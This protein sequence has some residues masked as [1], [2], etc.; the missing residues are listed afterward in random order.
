MSVIKRGISP[1]SVEGLTVAY[2]KKP[3]VRN[4]SFE[5][6]EGELI[7]IIGPNGAGKSTLIKSILGLQPKLAG[8]VNVYGKSYKLQ[9]RLVGY[10]PQRE[11]VDWDFPTN[12]LDVV[13]MG[14]YGHLGLFRRPGKRERA[15]SMDC[16]EK[17]GMGDFANRQ[18]SQLSGG[19]QQ[20]VFLARALAQDATLY[21]MDEPFAGVDA[22]TEKAIIT[23]LGELKRQ[24]KTVLVVHHDLA[25]VQEYFDSVMLLNVDLIAFGPTATTFTEENL[26]QAYGGRLAFVTKSSHQETATAAEIGV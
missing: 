17:V 22:A 24:G 26:Q 13:M 25:T 2:H 7:G 12:V 23:L 5:V 4:V 6:N 18:I 1:I 20:R 21:F 8:E 9:R 19:Q 10:V 14:R 16:L 15:I 11:S 3:V